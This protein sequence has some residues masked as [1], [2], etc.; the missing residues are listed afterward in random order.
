MREIKFRGRRV[1][2]GEWV[3]GFY[4]EVYMNYD[5]THKRGEITY[6][7]KYGALCIFEVILETVDQYTGLKDKNGVK[8]YEGDKLQDEGGNIITC[9]FEIQDSHS[10]FKFVDKKRPARM[11][12]NISTFFEIIGNI[13][14]K[15][16]EN[17][18]KN[19][20]ITSIKRSDVK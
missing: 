17:E 6:Y 11:Y 4:R 7:D 1:D 13:H 15:E 18:R 16:K 5:Y 8:I 9:L 10:S 19:Q 2:N 3:Y 20:A 14:D 12:C